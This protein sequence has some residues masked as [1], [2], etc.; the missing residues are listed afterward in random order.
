MIQP[1]LQVHS[2]YNCCCNPFSLRTKKRKKKYSP[3]RL[4]PPFYSFALSDP[5][6]RLPVLA[7][8]SRIM[9]KKNNIGIGLMSACNMALKRQPGCNKLKVN[10]SWDTNRPYIHRSALH[11]TTNNNNNTH[12]RRRTTTHKQIHQTSCGQQQQHQK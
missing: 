12:R 4:S 9:K 5:P 11:G 8:K 10:L 6:L 2:L 7:L 1:F 3:S